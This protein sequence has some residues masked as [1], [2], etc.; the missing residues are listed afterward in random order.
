[1]DT[2]DLIWRQGF[3]IHLC[4][5]GKLG[6]SYDK[7]WN[8]ILKHPRFRKNL[9]I[10]NDI[11]DTE[12]NYCYKH[13]KAMIFPSYAEGYG[14]PIVEALANGLPVIASNIPIHREVGKDFCT[15]FDINKPSCLAEI[16]ID[17]EKTGKMPPTRNLSAYDLPKWKDSCKE[18]LTKI[19]YLSKTTEEQQYY[20]KIRID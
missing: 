7:V 17:I 9:F 13:S 6:W 8:R 5:I 19:L 20:E 1:L 2:F 16:I 14:L 18:L 12:L 10:Y 4:I 11:N 15:Y 3:D